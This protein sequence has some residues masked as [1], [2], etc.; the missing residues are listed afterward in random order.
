MACLF[1]DCLITRREQVRRGG[2]EP[3][4]L[5]KVHLCQGRCRASLGKYRG[6]A[7]VLFG[8]PHSHCRP[9]APHLPHLAY[10]EIAGRR[11]SSRFVGS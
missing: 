8:Y 5:S 4:E 11:D 9:S 2:F 7:Q 3:P 6:S 10:L 1:F